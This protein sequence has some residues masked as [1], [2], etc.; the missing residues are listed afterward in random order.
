MS[1]SGGPATSPVFIPSA[2]RDAGT[3]IGAAL[4][5]HCAKQKRQPERGNSTPFLGPA[6]NRR[7]IL[8][9]VTFR[10]SGIDALFMD[11]VY[12]TAEG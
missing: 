7:E 11:D 10:K 6:F 3:A 9:I 12:L 8:A 1:R 4:L 2:P 5:M